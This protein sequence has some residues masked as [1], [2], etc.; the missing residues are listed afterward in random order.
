MITRTAAAGP[1]RFACL[2]DR[3][4][5]LPNAARSAG[6]YLACLAARRLIAAFA[7]ARATVGR[8]G[9]NCYRRGGDCGSGR[10]S[11]GGRS[12]RLLAASVVAA[13]RLLAAALVAGWRR[14]LRNCYCRRD[15]QCA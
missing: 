10:F 13:T 9:G 4:R 5:R 1:A 11:H 3:G 7:C 15:R 12:G 6:G 8:C 2:G 14:G